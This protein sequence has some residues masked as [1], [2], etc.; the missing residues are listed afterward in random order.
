MISVS[1]EMRF[2][3]AHR[4]INGYPGNC[5]HV[6]GHSWVARVTL[7][8]RRNED[9]DQYDFVE[10]YA[11]FKPL[12]AWVDTHWDHAILLNLND[13]LYRVLNSEE[14]RVNGRLHRVVGFNSNPTS[15]AVA[16]ELLTQ[17]Q[18]F[19]Q[20]DRVWVSRVEVEETCTSRCTLEP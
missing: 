12:R 4:L 9:L 11:S 10:D 5:A 13:P 19:L 6:H 16:R 2:E 17:A 18:M 8:L 15:E 14:F 20:N 3:T 1:K 7:T